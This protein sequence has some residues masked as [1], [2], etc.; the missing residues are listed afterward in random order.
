ML[1]QEREDFVPVSQSPIWQLVRSYY[2]QMGLKAWH[3]SAVPNYITTNPFIASRYAK[4]IDGFFAD[5]LK[6]RKPYSQDDPFYII[7]L[8]AGSGRF[9]FCF[10]KHFFSELEKSIRDNRNFVYVMTDISRTNIDF[11]KQHPQLQGFIKQGLLDFAYLDVLEHESIELLISGKTLAEGT[12]DTPM[13]VIANYVFDSLP[14]D[15]FEI[16]NGKLRAHLIRCKMDPGADDIADIARSTEIDYRAEECGKDYYGNSVWNAVLNEYCREEKN[17][18]FAIPVGGLTAI[19]NMSSLT[20]G[21]MFMLASDFG[22]S[23]ISSLRS[24]P[25]RRIATN[26][27]YSVRV[28]FHAVSRFLDRTGGRFYA[29]GCSKSSLETVG[30]VMNAGR[31]KHKNLSYAFQTH[32]K[33][34]GPDEFFMMKKIVERNFDSLDFEHIIG[35]LRM[36]CWDVKIFKGCAAALKECLEWLDPWQKSTVI[37]T[38]L[39]VDDM[40]FRCDNT[41]D[42][43]ISIVELLRA[44]GETALAQEIQQK[45]ET[46]GRFIDQVNALDRPAGDMG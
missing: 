41:V 23:D 1:T 7:E 9:G 14:H 33:N 31:K 28:N 44:M 6:S 12:T 35:T 22:D 26:G 34:F 39:D 4:V 8:G 36:S 11:W 3:T 42:P 20:S 2:R 18:N 32:I 15:L 19:E 37:Q 10:L 17:L 13:A 21:P 38:L 24:L 45:S 46:Y 29:P 5:F 25:K 40:Y 16:R 30:L 27:C 43:A